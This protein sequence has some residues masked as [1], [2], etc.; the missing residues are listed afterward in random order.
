MISRNGGLAVIQTGVFW[1]AFADYVVD[2]VCVAM[3]IMND[4]DDDD[5]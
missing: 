2:T 3:L 4:D 1:E 5:R